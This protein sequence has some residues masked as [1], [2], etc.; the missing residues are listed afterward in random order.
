MDLYMEGAAGKG[1]FKGYIK[2]LMKNI[3]VLELPREDKS[4][5]ELVKGTFFKIAAFLFQN[6]KKDDIATK[7]DF[8]GSFERPRMDL[9]GALFN[10]FRNGFF[11]G[12]S[13]GFEEEVKGTPAG[14]V[15]EDAAAPEATKASPSE[16]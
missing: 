9:V 7:I 13:P 1:M 16:T 5:G 10:F 3:E 11:E 12:I 8:E 14:K 4:A 15:S 2:P 6:R